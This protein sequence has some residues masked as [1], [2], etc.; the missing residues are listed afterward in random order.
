MAT[1]EEHLELEATE[2]RGGWRYSRREC[3]NMTKFG[4]VVGMVR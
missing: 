2:G 3:R 4:G 1:I